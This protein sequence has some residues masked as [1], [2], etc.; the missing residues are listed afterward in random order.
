LPGVFGGPVG[1]WGARR[2]PVAINRRP[3]SERV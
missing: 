3:D 2:R 1:S